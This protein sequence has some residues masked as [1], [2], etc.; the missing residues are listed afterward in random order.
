MYTLS[1]ASRYPKALNKRHL[2]K[3][4]SF[5]L[6]VGRAVTLRCRTFSFIHSCRH[7]CVSVTPLLDPEL[8]RKFGLPFS[9]D[10]MHPMLVK[11]MVV[12][13]LMLM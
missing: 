13:T 8:N 3:G 5:Y 2:A 11:L 10:C 7:V 9:R 1:K 6:C 12:A 4:D